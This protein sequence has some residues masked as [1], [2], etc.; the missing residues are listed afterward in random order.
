MRHSDIHQGL[1]SC[2]YKLSSQSVHY[3]NVG[4]MV[5]V[6]W[7]KNLTVDIILHYDKEYPLIK[8][9]PFDEGWSENVV[10]FGILTVERFHLD[11]IPDTFRPFLVWEDV[12]DQYI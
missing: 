6:A 5:F 8:T 7:K 9:I 1:S 3:K 11:S 12:K 10:E 4:G 2:G